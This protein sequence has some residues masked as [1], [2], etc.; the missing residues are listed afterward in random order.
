MLIVAPLS[1]LAHWQRE[2]ESWTDLN[3]IVYHG[4]AEDRKCIREYE[5]AYECDRPVGGIGFNQLYLKKCGR[6]SQTKAE[7]PWMIDVVVTTPE[8]MV[9]DDYAELTAVPWELL[10]V[11]E[12]HRLK[13]HQSKLAVT[14]RSDR[15]T[16]KHKILLTGYVSFAVED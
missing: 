8:I 15:F 13:N 2:F 10:V 16:F 6:K 7:S 14:L 3:T 9:A 1:T 12:A 11:D 5:F 4:S